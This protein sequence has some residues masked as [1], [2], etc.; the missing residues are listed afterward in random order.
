MSDHKK[1]MV[2]VD[3]LLAI[4][5]ELRLDLRLDSSTKQWVCEKLNQ[6]GHR[7][8][9]HGHASHHILEVSTMIVNGEPWKD[10]PW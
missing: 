1:F 7:P 4:L 8:E 6:L 9:L 5:C 10:R 2:A 3:G